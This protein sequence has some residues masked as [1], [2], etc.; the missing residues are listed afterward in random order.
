MSAGD[1]PDV[2]TGLDRSMAMPAPVR[3]FAWGCFDVFD[4][5]AEHPIHLSPGREADV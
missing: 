1:L 3:Y 5:E 2:S 4:W